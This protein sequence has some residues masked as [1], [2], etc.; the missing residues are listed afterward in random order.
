MW[1]S[2]TSLSIF[3]APELLFMPD[4]S[5][6]TS[7]TSMYLSNMS[8]V[9][10]FKWPSSLVHGHFV[11]INDD[12]DWVGF[13]TLPN[14]RSITFE[15]SRLKDIQF[16]DVHQLASLVLEDLPQLS[17]LT[18]NN[19]ALE[20]FDINK[21]G[22]RSAGNSSLYIDLSDVMAPGTAFSIDATNEKLATSCL[23]VRLNET[24]AMGAVETVFL[25]GLRHP[26]GISLE[27][28]HALNTLTIAD[29]ELAWFDAQH[30][31]GSE[32]GFD[33]EITNT[34]FNVQSVYFANKRHDSKWGVDNDVVDRLRSLSVTSSQFPKLVIFGMYGLTSLV[35]SGGRNTFE[36]R[37]DDLA[38]S[39]LDLSGLLTNRSDLKMFLNNVSVIGHDGQLP[40]PF[41]LDGSDGLMTSLRWLEFVGGPTTQLST[42]SLENLSRLTYL[43]IGEIGSLTSLKVTNTDLPSLPIVRFDNVSSAGVSVDFANI[44]NFSTLSLDLQGISPLD[45]AFLRS[46]RSLTLSDDRGFLS[47]L[48]IRG[49]P[50]LAALS[51][52][53]YPSLLNL[54]VSNCSALTSLNLSTLESATQIK[55]DLTNLQQVEIY[56]TSGLYVSLRD[57]TIRNSMLIRSIE[58]VDLGR[59]RTVLL[60]GMP[61]LTVFKMTNC[62]FPTFN[63]VGIQGGGGV[64]VTLDGV[65]SEPNGTPIIVQWNNTNAPALIGSLRLRALSP[66]QVLNLTDF[67]Q[68]ESVS[69][70]DSVSARV[71]DIT[72]CPQ[73]SS[74]DIGGIEMSIGNF[75]LRRTG[76]TSVDMTRLARNTTIVLENN[77]ALTGVCRLPDDYNGNCSISGNAF[78]ADFNC[79]EFC[80]GEEI[81]QVG[82]VPVGQQQC[83]LPPQVTSCPTSN[84]ISY[85]VV[86]R[87]ATVCISFDHLPDLAANTSCSARITN[88]GLSGSTIDTVNFVRCYARVEQKAVV[89]L[90]F[91]GE[92]RSIELRSGKSN[93]TFCGLAET[94]EL[95]RNGTKVQFNR[96]LATRATFC[97][98]TCPTPP[99][100]TTTT[101]T[102]TTT[103]E[104]ASTFNA[105]ETNDSNTALLMDSPM[106]EVDFPLGVVIGATIGGLALIA[107]ALAGFVCAL[108][109]RNA[110][111]NDGNAMKAMQIAPNHT[112]TK[113]EYGV[114]TS[115]APY[116]DVSDVR[117][118]GGGPITEYTRM[119]V[120]E[121]AYDRPPVLTSEYEAT[122]DKLS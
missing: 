95:V 71:V 120:A 16:T 56:G 113:S 35:A 24:S 75:S 2:L 15:S 27:R 92:T 58:L 90:H 93:H 96:V 114:F 33:I 64:A 70:R 78:Y 100:P 1:H 41:T 42:I 86:D 39:H 25:R 8:K 37:L 66:I 22:G 5:D 110:S 87:G 6:L 63:L 105:S 44:G 122:T 9:G 76:L 80:D 23:G 67:D 29:C 19:A 84:S 48:Q 117:A 68:L 50:K 51:L 109:K 40:S 4:L 57:L 118:G 119:T 82:T 88:S 77:I 121:S 54:D 99:P 62:S 101:T 115:T 61:S 91:V 97:G 112:T 26:T 98:E 89:D 38:L 7:L 103:T 18:M 17:H 30:I 28:L 45:G 60:S 10:Y 108:K 36:V 85:Q 32:E 21:I 65:V 79:A 104:V 59:L 13:E 83:P 52:S 20:S 73:L 14:L 43:K 34:S 106:I 11:N 107:L 94:V 72:N 31:G 55:L 116:N 69:L 12:G 46:L 47:S 49:L 53:D 3:D 102:T 74:L 111:D 81:V